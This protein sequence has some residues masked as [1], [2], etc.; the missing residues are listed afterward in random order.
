[1]MSKGTDGQ[2]WPLGIIGGQGADRVGLV[3]QT[4]DEPQLNENFQQ[5]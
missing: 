5:R 1:M 2:G 3:A 4:H